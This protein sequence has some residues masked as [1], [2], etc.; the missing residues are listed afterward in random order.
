ML[1]CLSC[2]SDHSGSV[3]NHIQIPAFCG[4]DFKAAIALCDLVHVSRA[5]AIGEPVFQA[6]AHEWRI[7]VRISCFLTVLFSTN[8]DKLTA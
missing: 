1:H 8:S 6:G 2:P 5:R 3:V 7:L 4:E